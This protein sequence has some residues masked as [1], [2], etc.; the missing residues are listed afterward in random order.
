MDLL[1]E[2]YASPF[3]LLDEV[4]KQERLMDFI[5]ELDLIKDDEKTF[6]VWLHKI[7]DQGYREFKESCKPKPTNNVS[8]EAD[9]EAVIKNSNDILNSF[10]PS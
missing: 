1:F 6:N 5:Y 2:R 8:K 9:L 10:I 4:I 3:L 7:D